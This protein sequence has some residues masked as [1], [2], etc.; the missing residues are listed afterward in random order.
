M[1]A[2]VPSKRQLLEV[3]YPGPVCGA[4]AGCF[5]LIFPQYFY[6]C[7]V[8]YRIRTYVSLKLDA[9]AA[10]GEVKRI[11]SCHCGSYSL[12]IQFIYIV[13]LRFVASGEDEH[14]GGKHKS[15]TL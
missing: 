2:Q 13:G 1:A 3:L 11:T 7:R 8:L 14:Y 15:V 5:H 6:I 12:S 10:V 4:Y 9:G